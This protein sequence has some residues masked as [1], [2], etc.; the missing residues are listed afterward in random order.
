MGKSTLIER[1]RQLAAGLKIATLIGAGDATEQ[2]TPY[3]AWRSIFAQIF[4]LSTAYAL[5]ARI[6]DLLGADEIALAPLLNTVLPL[7]P[8]ESQLISQLTGQRRAEATRDLLLRLLQRAVA[9]A[10]QLLILEDAHWFDSASW[11]LTLA[12]SQRVRPLLLVIALRPPS[13]NASNDAGPPEYRQLLAAAKARLRLDALAPEEAI[14][15]VCQRLGVE[16]LPEPVAQ[17]IREKAQGHLL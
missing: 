1:L 11:E 5:D 13:S 6:R 14:T 2:S 10:P 7:N 16:A 17:L 15:L 12:A 8:P 3:H 4:D 9:Q